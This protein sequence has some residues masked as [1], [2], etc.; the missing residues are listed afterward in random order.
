MRRNLGSTLA[1]AL[2]VMML[3]AGLAP[4]T[5]DLMHAGVVTL[6]GAFAYRS[7]KKRRLAEVPNSKMRLALELTAMALLIASVLLLNDL[8]YRLAEHPFPTGFVPLWAVVAYIVAIW[9]RKVPAVAE[10]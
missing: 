10:R 7:A 3:A 1:I 6:L 5:S 8:Q 9:P 2:G 4:H